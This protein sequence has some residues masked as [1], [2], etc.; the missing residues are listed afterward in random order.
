MSFSTFFGGLTLI[1]GLVIV[2]QGLR[3][4][5]RAYPQ[6]WLARVGRILFG[7]GMGAWGGY[8]AL[9][10]SGSPADTSAFARNT[11]TLGWVLAG[12]VIIL[13]LG[14]AL[15]SGRGLL[16]ARSRQRQLEQREYPH[17]A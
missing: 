5:P 6:S 3:G 14:S 8:E 7:L 10:Y 2:V 17:D 1:L 13:L 9:G 16:V 4:T 15:A 12:L 11:P